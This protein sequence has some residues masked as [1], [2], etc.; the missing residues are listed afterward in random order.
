MNSIS[1]GTTWITWAPKA[2]LT[3]MSQYVDK[4][5]ITKQDSN[6][7][8]IIV[9][10]PLLRALSTYHYNMVNMPYTLKPPVD[11]NYSNLYLNIRRVYPDPSKDAYDYERFLYWIDQVLPITITTDGHTISQTQ[12]WKLPNDKHWRLT[13]IPIEW[14]C[15]EDL[16]K[17]LLQTF[18]WVTTK[19]NKQDYNQKQCLK[20]LELEG[21][22]DALYKYYADDFAAYKTATATDSN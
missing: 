16:D 19:Q 12:S 15:L 13:D 10:D 21:V 11:D 4:K 2:G 9:R 17:H 22:Q 8:I 3:T 18:G 6:R 20:Y 5:L 14:W 7:I 1:I